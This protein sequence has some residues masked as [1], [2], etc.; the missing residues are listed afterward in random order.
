MTILKED[1]ARE[2]LEKALSHSQA[3]G[4]EVTLNGS[5]TG[6]IRYARNTVTTAGIVDDLTLVVQSNYGKKM[7]TA[8]INE[9]DDDS[10]EKVVRRSEELAQLAPENPEFMPVL[11]PQKYLEAKGWFD[12]TSDI[13][14]KFR[15]QASASSIGPCKEKKLVAAGFLEDTSGFQAI[16]NSAGL[17]AYYPETTCSFSV[18]VRTEDGTGSGW[19]RRDFNDAALLDT[20]KA[21]GVAMEKAEMSRKAKAIEPGKYT[22][23]LEPAAV[24]GLL[25]NMMFNFNARPADEGRSFLTKAGGGTRLGEKIVDERVNLYSDPSNAE[26]PA[27]PWAGDG[28]ARTRIHW[29]KNGVVENM[30]R[31][32]FWAEKTEKPAIPFPA[33]GIMDGTDT[34]LEALIRDTKRGVLVTRLWYI[35]TVDP[36]TLLYTGLTRDGTFFIENGKI[37]YPIKNMRFNES[38]VIM[39]NNLEALGRPTRIQ[40]SLLPP[41]KVRDFTFSSLSDA[42]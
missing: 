26:V 32:R 20:A 13:D 39:L 25:Q 42:V 5:R 16:A 30:F 38:P 14:S 28:Q 6:N 19:S 31:E 36:Q 15:A 21:S 9:L 41:V 24:R 12:S 18:T 37:A 22:V 1:E 2:L 17:A 35:R 27:S 29:I 3:E 33:N 8:T 34:S 4:C 7:G 40:E 11:G 10:I 23:I